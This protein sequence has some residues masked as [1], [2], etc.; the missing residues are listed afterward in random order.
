MTKIVFS[1]VSLREGYGQEENVM[2]LIREALGSSK[3][4]Q[5]LK[6]NIDYDFGNTLIFG[7]FDEGKLVCMNVFMR[8]LFTC[9]GRKLIAYQSGFSATANSHRG[10]G[11]WPKLMAFAEEKL[12]GLGAS[13]IFGYPNPVSHPL[14]SKKLQYTTLDLCTLIVARVPYW[15]KAYLKVLPVNH[16]G[17][18]KPDLQDNIAWKERDRGSVFIYAEAGSLIWGKVRKVKKLGLYLHFL[19]VG[20]FELCSSDELPKLF[21]RAMEAVG[22]RLLYLSINRENEYFH[23]F[24]HWRKQI[25]PVIIKPLGSFSLDMRHLNFFGG[26]R[27]TY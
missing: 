17:V 18:I 11:L 1:D 4:L 16:A 3:S 5:D 7:G 22:V 19:D 26:M 27:D 8:M 9:D 2:A 15:T 10:K 24:S 12:G 6:Y 23:M 25:A 14:F 13:F 20:G 21:N